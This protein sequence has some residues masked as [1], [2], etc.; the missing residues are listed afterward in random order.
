MIPAAHYRDYQDLTHDTYTEVDDI[1]H[2]KQII[3]DR[4]RLIFKLVQTMRTGEEVLGISASRS[5]LNKLPP[6]EYDLIK[7]YM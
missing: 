1:D 4:E 6:E 2:L 7:G 5:C 3:K